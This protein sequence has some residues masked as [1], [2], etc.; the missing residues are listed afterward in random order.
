MYFWHC[1]LCFTF[2][3]YLIFK[4][5]CRT[6]EG[7]VLSLLSR[8][9]ACGLQR[10]SSITKVTQITPSFDDGIQ[11]R[12]LEPQVHSLLYFF[13]FFLLII[14]Q[15]P[16]DLSLRKVSIPQNFWIKKI[17]VLF[18]LS[19]FA[20]LHVIYCHFSLIVC[21]ANTICQ[22][23]QLDLNILVSSQQIFRLCITH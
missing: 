16:L 14:F 2:L 10:S 3:L 19:F 12:Y 17:D 9:A 20:R 11:A 23:A 21:Q 13:F 18:Q 4:P 15:Y 8:R 22:L 1:S 7:L 6:V 5:S